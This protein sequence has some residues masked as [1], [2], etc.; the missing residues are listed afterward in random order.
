MKRFL[1]VASI[2]VWTAILCVGSLAQETKKVLLLDDFE[3]KI[4]VGET[5]DAGSGNGSSVNV[6]AD[7]EIKH[8]GQQS[9][10]IVY[11]AVAGGY[12][13]VARGFGLDVKGAAQWLQSPEKI[14]WSRYGAIS[15]YM[16]GSGSNARMAFDIK[17]AGGEM[18]RFMVTDDFKGWKLIVCAF[19]QFFPRG[20]WQPPTA[21]VNGKLDF[22][23]KSFQFEPIAVAKGTLYVDEVALE[24]LN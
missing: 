12:I 15:F 13:W 7:K 14:D 10:K 2:F 24:P 4:I 17:D 3:G 1:I 20:D 19:D 22:P 8:S 11:D 9:L 18:F 23:I 16:Y 5:I 21:Q 6:S